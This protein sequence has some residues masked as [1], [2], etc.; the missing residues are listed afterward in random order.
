[1]QVVPYGLFLGFCI[2]YN[3]T[4]FFWIADRLVGCDIEILNWRGSAN[5]ALDLCRVG[6]CIR[7]SWKA[8]QCRFT[9]LEGAVSCGAR[10][11]SKG[12]NAACHHWRQ[13]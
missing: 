6:S 3:G 9:P 4:L 7:S 1:M 11:H 10:E 13:C 8:R 2:A 5:V 12:G